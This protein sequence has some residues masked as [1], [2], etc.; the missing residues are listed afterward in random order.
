MANM[1]RQGTFSDEALQQ[2]IDEHYVTVR[3]HPDWPLYIYNYTAKAAYDDFWNEVTVNCRGLICN[4]AGRVL[5]RPFKKFFW[6][7]HYPPESSIFKR[8]YHVHKKYDGSLGIAY[9]PHSDSRPMIAT[10]GSFESDQAVK[11]TQILWDKYPDFDI[12]E[13]MTYLFEIIYPQNRVVLNYGDTED[14]VLLDVVGTLSGHSYLFSQ[15]PESAGNFFGW[16][17]PIAERIDVDENMSPHDVLSLAN[18]DGS[19]EGFV[20]AFVNEDSTLTRMKVKTEEY[21][22]LHYEKYSLSNIIIWDQLRTGKPI[23]EI[24]GE[25]PDEYYGWVK[26]IVAAIRSEYT[27]IFNEAVEEFR[28]I[29]DKVDPSDLSGANRKLFAEHA[30]QCKHQH[31]LFAM[32]DGNQEAVDNM[33]YKRI[34]P[35]HEPA[36]IVIEEGEAQPSWDN[37]SVNA[38]TPTVAV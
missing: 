21:C 30:K 4:E 10:R 7:N 9:K 28:S 23:N 12:R 31:L 33:I 5:A 15:S 27:T 34:R 1:F 20:L 17:G 37:L 11:A 14:L 3:K 29:T 13:N 16:P 18:P 22:R 38:E 19:E 25:C 32:F 6:T 26:G 35:V 24:I 8:P 36:Y 2:A